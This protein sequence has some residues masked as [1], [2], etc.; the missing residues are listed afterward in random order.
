M[1]RGGGAESGDR[2]QLLGPAGG[3]LEQLDADQPASSDVVLKC[4]LN[5]LPGTSGVRVIAH[6]IKVDGPGGGS[7]SSSGT[8]GI[9]LTAGSGSGQCNAGATV[10]LESTS[11]TDGNPNGDIRITGCGDVVVNSSTVSSAGATVTVSSSNGKVCALGDTV[12]GGNVTVTADGDLTMHG[13]GVT[14]G[15]STIKLTSNSGSVLAGAV[16]CPPN[17]FTGGND[18]NMTVTAKGRIDLTGACVE[19]A[20]DITFTATGTGFACS[21]DVI[22]SLNSAEVR[23]D[24]GQKGVITGTAC[25]GTGRIDIGNAI[26][27]D[28]GKNGGAFDPNK[29]SKLNGSLATQPFNCAN[30][31][32]PTCTTRPLDAANNPVSASPA[33][34]AAHHVTGVPRCDT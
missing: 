18:S 21:I 20:Q 2:H 15:T 16:F 27:V 14:V 30:V 3:G 9:Q 25:G 26:L 32:T 33:D 1:R 24:F 29:V 19:I 11:V 22:L 6:S 28:N 7:V 13:T 34:R 12:S 8:S 5:Q 23:N 4:A 31:T 10:D 17:R